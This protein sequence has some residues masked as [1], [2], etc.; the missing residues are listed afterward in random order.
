MVWPQAFYGF[1][2]QEEIRT[3]AIR[4]QAMRNRT[5]ATGRKVSFRP[6]FPQMGARNAAIDWR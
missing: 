6:V 3:C 4:M 1:F 2:R 5:R